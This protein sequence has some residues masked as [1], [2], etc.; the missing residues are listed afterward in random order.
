MFFRRVKGIPCFQGQPKWCL[1]DV[2]NWFQRLGKLLGRA[3]AP[4]SQR[5]HCRNRPQS[6]LDIFLGFQGCG[7][8]GCEGAPANQLQI[9]GSLSL[10]L[11]INYL[12]LCVFLPPFAAVRICCREGNRRQSL[13]PAEGVL[14]KTFLDGA[15]EKS[16][17]RTLL[18]QK[19]QKISRDF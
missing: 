7:L 12:S 11:F 17:V 9:P 15:Q 3:A 4:T 1:G 19:Y 14:A 8:W 10:Y 5:Q 13:P 16:Q 2:K 18:Q 6:N